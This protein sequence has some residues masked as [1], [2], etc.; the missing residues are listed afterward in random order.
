MLKGSLG[1]GI[2][3]MPE[4]FHNAGYGLGIFGTLFIGALCTYC[5]HILIR[6]QYI[7]C[8]RLRVPVLNYPDTMVEAIEIGPQWL[9]RFKNASRHIVNAFLIVY[10][11]GICCVYIVFVATNIKQVVDEYWTHLDVRVYMVMLLPPLIL[12]NYIP[13]LKFLAPFSTAANVMTFVGL[14]IVLYYLF[15]TG[16]PH[17]GERNVIG[18]LSHFPLFIGTTLFALE[19]VGVVSI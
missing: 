15:G 11:L 16:V 18:E 19:A 10:Q 6:S 1:T 12:L 4:A 7:L 8:S 14:G 9:R 3:A 17:I 13:N 5:L 2:L